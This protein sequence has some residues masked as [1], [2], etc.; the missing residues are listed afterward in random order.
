MA[1]E[2]SIPSDCHAKVYIGRSEKE[3]GAIWQ[4]ASKLICIKCQAQVTAGVLAGIYLS[5]L[6]SLPQG[7]SCRCGS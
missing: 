7:L 6:S 1:L 3:V 4:D 5:R 2:K